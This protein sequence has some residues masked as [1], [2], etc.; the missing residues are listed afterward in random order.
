MATK[1]AERATSRRAKRNMADLQRRL[2][3]LIQLE[4]VGRVCGYLM[5]REK[6]PAEDENASFI[7][8]TQEGT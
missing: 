3:E 1:R 7:K 6:H 4:A 5:Q 8:G 2:L